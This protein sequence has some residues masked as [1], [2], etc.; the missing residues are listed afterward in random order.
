M[1]TVSFRTN[2]FNF[3]VLIRK[4]IGEYGHRYPFHFLAQKLH[5]SFNLERETENDS[6]EIKKEKWKKEKCFVFKMHALLI[7]IVFFFFLLRLWR[8]KT[9]KTEQWTSCKWNDFQWLTV[10]ERG[11]KKEMSGISLDGEYSHIFRQW[12]GNRSFQRTT[13][14]CFWT[15]K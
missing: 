10:R 15:R 13:C 12:Y 2:H 11:K 4:Y 7:E 6:K 3:H 1:G 9:R 5:S 14:C 8:K